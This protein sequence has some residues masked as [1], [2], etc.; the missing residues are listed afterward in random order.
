MPPILFNS[1]SKDSL[2]LVQ[3]HISKNIF[4]F[5]LS[6]IEFADLRISH[7]PHTLGRVRRFHLSL[8]KN[9]GETD[10]QVGAD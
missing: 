9:L 8:W 4:F 6:Y 1:N 10:S 2:E 7:F 5:P 3:N